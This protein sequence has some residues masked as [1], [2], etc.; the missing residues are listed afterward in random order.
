[1]SNIN[2]ACDDICFQCRQRIRFEKEENVTRCHACGVNNNRTIVE[3]VSNLPLSYQN[4]LNT[5]W[6]PRVVSPSGEA[7]FV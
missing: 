5:R 6:V 7:L 3:P 2:E 1:M 4:T